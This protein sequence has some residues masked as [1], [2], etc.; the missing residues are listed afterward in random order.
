VPLPLAYLL[1]FVAAVPFI[2]IALSIL[3]SIALAVLEAGRAILAVF[4]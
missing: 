3:L 2:I 4:K 1:G